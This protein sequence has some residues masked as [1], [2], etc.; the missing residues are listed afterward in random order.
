MNNIKTYDSFVNELF[1]QRRDMKTRKNLENIKKITDKQKEDE[2]EFK[3]KKYKKMR[4]DM[5]SDL[6]KSLEDN[7]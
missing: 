6:E 5:I 3:L 7:D 2:P 1:G 4:D